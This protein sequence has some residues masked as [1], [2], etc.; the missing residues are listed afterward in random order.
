MALCVKW[1]CLVLQIDDLKSFWSSPKTLKKNTGR[2]P[3]K[4]Q[5][6]SRIQHYLYGHG[7]ENKHKN[8]VIGIKISMERL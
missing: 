8:E 1:L 3:K 2:V 7:S 6:V 4:S 5:L